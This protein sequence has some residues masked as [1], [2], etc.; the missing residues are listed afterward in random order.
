MK[1]K[2]AQ[3][4]LHARPLRKIVAILRPGS[5]P[6]ENSFVRLA[7]GHET[8]AQGKLRA[9]CPLC[10]Q[11]RGI[12][13]VKRRV[14]RKRRV[15]IRTAKSRAKP[16]IRRE[17]IFVKPRAGKTIAHW[18]RFTASIKA[19]DRRA[20]DYVAQRLEDCLREIDGTVVLL[21][22]E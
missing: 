15:K 7:C 14:P 12:L 6:L 9:R 20:L 5:T 16:K 8:Y 22:E 17:V 18:L 10:K 13:Q 1:H 3:V 19:S 2:L 11:T 21:E 4:P